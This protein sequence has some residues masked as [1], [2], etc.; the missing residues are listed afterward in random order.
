MAAIDKP[1]LRV[2]AFGI[3]A[4]ALA[5]GGAALAQPAPLAPRNPVN[6]GPG[7]IDASQAADFIGRNVVACGLASHP[8]PTLHSLSLGRYVPGNG[9]MGADLLAL[10]TPQADIYAWD[11]KTIC[12]GGVVRLQTITIDPHTQR[13]VP[14]IAV[15]DPQQVRVLGG[16][17]R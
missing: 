11:G 6:Y 8:N 15:Q 7:R 17:R 4:A 14:T 3:A 16:G 12:V 10:F 5:F 13:S 1:G 9:I 2:L